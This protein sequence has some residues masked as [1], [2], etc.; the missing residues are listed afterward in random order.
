MKYF[1]LCLILILTTSSAF[2]VNAF[3]DSK[4]P[5]ETDFEKIDATEAVAIANAWK[6]SRKDVKSF[7]TARE[8]VFQFSDGKQK[9][10]ALPQE[11]M[12]VAVAPYIRRT[13]K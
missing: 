6:W 11:K 13:H 8:V 2:Q 5:A 4:N 10:I 12:L 1:I 7:V 3:Q 9:K